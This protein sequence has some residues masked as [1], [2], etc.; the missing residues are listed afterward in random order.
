MR[1]EASNGSG[2]AELVE[3]LD[4]H[5]EHILAEGQLAQRR[6]R[7]LRSEVLAIATARM[8]R[9][10]EEGLSDDPEFQSL[11]EAV[12]SRQLD[13]ASAAGILLERGALLERAGE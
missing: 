5:R 9:R 2:V 3:H 10:L 4:E 12:V 13:P 11:V 6:S 8:R 7:N 1:T